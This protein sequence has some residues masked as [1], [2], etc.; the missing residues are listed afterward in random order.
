M[1]M[2]LQ[3]TEYAAALTMRANQTRIAPRTAQDV[4]IRRLQGKRIQDVAFRMHVAQPKPRDRQGRPPV[5]P[6][7]LAA[8]RA[9]RDAGERRRTEKDVEV[10]LSSVSLQAAERHAVFSQLTSSC[11]TKA[12][13]CACPCSGLE[14]HRVSSTQRGL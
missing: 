13:S 7:G 8:A 11:S 1:T 14:Q 5:I 9:R 10:R 12:W 2:K 6:A 3:P 4:K